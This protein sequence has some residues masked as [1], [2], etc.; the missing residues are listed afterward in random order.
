MDCESG[1]IGQTLIYD[2]VA[3][4]GFVAFSLTATGVV[5]SGIYVQLIHSR[6][7]DVS[8]Q[9]LLNF[10]IFNIS[11]NHHSHHIGVA[12]SGKYLKMLPTRAIDVSWQKLVNLLR[13]QHFH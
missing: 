4:T 9:Q 5:V 3:M 12:V 2:V 11:T 7:I 6:G 1:C 13:F 8:W 10:S